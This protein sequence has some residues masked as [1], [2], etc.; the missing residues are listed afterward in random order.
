MIFLPV[1]DELID[2]VNVI[3]VFN[4]AYPVINFT[5]ERGEES[6]LQFHST[7]NQSTW[8]LYTKKSAP[9]TVME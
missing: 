5:S 9:Q 3:E 2:L 8:K 7:F 4:A 6:S 1:T